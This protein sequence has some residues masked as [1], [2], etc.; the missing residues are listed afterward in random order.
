MTDWQI[1][2]ALIIGGVAVGLLYNISVKMDE[3]VRLL[4][5]IDGRDDYRMGQTLRN[6]N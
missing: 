3:A 5:Q 6:S 1:T 4:R 2:L